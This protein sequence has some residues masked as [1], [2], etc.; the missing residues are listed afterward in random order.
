MLSQICSVNV[1]LCIVLLIIPL[2]LI[3]V[4]VCSYAVIYRVRQVTLKTI[5]IVTS[6]SSNAITVTYVLASAL[7]N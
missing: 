6:Q 4:V 7:E 5:T 2:T 3:A 1:I